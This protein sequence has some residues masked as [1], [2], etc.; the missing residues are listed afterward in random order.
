MD[1]RETGTYQQVAIKA[2]SADIFDSKVFFRFSFS[3][4]T[5]GFEIKDDE[6]TKILFFY[7]SFSFKE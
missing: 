1:G 2:K 3:C 5:E 4:Y 7:M 6:H